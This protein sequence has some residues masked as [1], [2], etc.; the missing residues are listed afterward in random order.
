MTEWRGSERLLTVGHGARKSALS[1]S[2][3][4]SFAFIGGSLSPVGFTDFGP[5]LQLDEENFHA[6]ER[7]C[8]NGS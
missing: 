4:R 7:R 5:Q 3:W 6:L 2:D 1:P 8:A